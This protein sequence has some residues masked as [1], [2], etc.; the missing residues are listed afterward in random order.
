MLRY[1]FF[2][3]HSLPV[4]LFVTDSTKRCHKKNIINIETRN[5]PMQILIH[6]ALTHRHIRDP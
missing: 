5:D 2:L 1:H 4:L 6:N 3:L